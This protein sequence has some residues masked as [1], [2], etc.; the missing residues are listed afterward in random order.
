[1]CHAIGGVDRLAV[2]LVRGVL[3]IAFDDN[4]VTDPVL[5]RCPVR[6]LGEDGDGVPA[7]V[8]LPLALLVLTGILR[9]DVD[10]EGLVQAGDL[11][12]S[13]NKAG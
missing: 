8:I 12:D 1:M 2:L 13:A 4:E 9:T 7:G 11:G 6:M 10:F 3:E 5:C